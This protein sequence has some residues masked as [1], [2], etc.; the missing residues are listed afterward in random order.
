MLVGIVICFYIYKY[1]N[2]K[3]VTQSPTNLLQ[4]IQNTPYKAGT[5][6]YITF[7]KYYLCSRTKSDD[8]KNIPL[9]LT[10]LKGENC[11][12]IFTENSLIKY[13]LSGM[14]MTIYDTAVNGVEKNIVKYVLVLSNTY[15]VDNSLFTLTESSIKHNK[16]NLF[17]SLFTF[18]VKSSADITDE[19]AS[20]TPITLAPTQYWTTNITTFT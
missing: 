17:L 13:S 6:F 10:P 15:S 20:N 19:I 7:G 2:S 14:Y 4:S 18:F 9:I 11:K 3:T 12:F 16:T 5:P 8:P 1:K